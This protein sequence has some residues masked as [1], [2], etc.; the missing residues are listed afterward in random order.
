MYKRINGNFHGAS[1][2]G[3]IIKSIYGG[4]EIRM[5]DNNNGVIDCDAVGIEHGGLICFPVPGPI[6]FFYEE[7]NANG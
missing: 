7:D 2:G 1:M 4:R 6:H 3:K 5:T